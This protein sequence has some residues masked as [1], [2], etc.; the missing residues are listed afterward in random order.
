MKKLFKTIAIFIALMLTLTVCGCSVYGDGYT[1][2]D[3]SST[4]LSTPATVESFSYSEYRSDDFVAFNQKLNEFSAKFTHAIYENEQNSNFV[5]SPVSV[6]SAMAIAVECASGQTRQ[7]LL[8]ALGVDYD[9]L[10]RNFDLLYSRLNKSKKDDKGKISSELTFS[11]SVWLDKHILYNPNILPKLEQTFYAYSYWAD[12]KY[13]NQVAN[14]DVSTFIKNA[15][16][17]IIDAEY[18]FSP[19]TLALL[20]NTL[21]LKDNW[22]VD[23]NDL[24]FTPDEKTFLQNDGVR[25]TEKFLRAYYNYGRAYHEDTFSFFF[26]TTD[27]GYKIKFVVPKDGYSISQVWTEQNI[28]KINLISNFNPVDNQ[29][30]E[31]YYTRCL[32]PEFEAE[33]DEDIKKVLKEK[34][35]ISNL[36][37]S[38]A[39]DFSNLAIEPI[40]CSKVFHTAKLKVDKKGI[41]GAAV[42]IFGMDGTAG[43]G[44]DPYTN[45]YFDFLV[46]RAFGFI[47]TDSYNIPLFSGVI[48]SL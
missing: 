5:V 14:Q 25:V 42:T 37:N 16:K 31:R 11:N 27:N 10:C 39:C 32:F 9:T 18:D 17:G 48:N 33:F 24:P 4:C 35:G 40:F 46:D 7:E 3:I 44:E 19:E 8:D 13:D 30:R 20:I 26:T 38:Y 36:F 15:T 28:A 34:L 21:Y 41:E 45:K 43:P 23:G 47:V 6:F 2:Q 29:K 22:D 1:D 12:F